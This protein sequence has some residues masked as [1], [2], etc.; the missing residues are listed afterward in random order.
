MP[1][2]LKRVPIVIASCVAASLLAVG[3]ARAGTVSD[4]Q[5]A[6]IEKAFAEFQKR[7]AIPDASAPVVQWSNAFERGSRYY[8]IKTNTSRDIAV[9]VGT[10][11]D[12][13]AV[14]LRK[15]FRF[16]MKLRR[17]NIWATRTREDFVNVAASELGIPVGPTT[18]G[19]WTRARGGTIVLPYVKEANLH[20]GN[21]MMHEATHQFLHAAIGDRIPTWV[22]EGLAV[23]FEESRYNPVERRL[24][25]FIVPRARLLHLQME[26]RMNAHVKLDELLKTPQYAFTARHYAAAWSFCYWVFRSAADDHQ[27]T[28]RRQKAF[29]TYLFD[30]KANRTNV[31]RL[32][33][34]LRMGRADAAKKWKK[35]VL[36][37]DPDDERGGTRLKGEPPYTPKPKPKRKGPEVGGPA[38]ELPSELLKMLREGKEI[39]PEMIKKLLK[40]QRKKQQ[41]QNR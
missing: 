21:V 14:A 39:P 3:P 33:M 8:Q 10:I 38:L 17:I 35:W 19:F 12:A 41:E 2:S 11:M 36:A 27:E 31:G 13:Q 6:R 16:P 1:R 32:F 24:E 30:I 37:L 22:D 23:M 34:Y 15:I 29:N 4:A 26:M 18:G 20:P 9:Y 5:N 40:E 25:V 28:L 7:G